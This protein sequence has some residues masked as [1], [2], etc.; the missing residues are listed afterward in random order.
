MCWVHHRITV[1]S[2]KQIKPQ[3]KYFQLDVEADYR[4]AN[5]TDRNPGRRVTKSKGGV[6]G[7][8]ADSG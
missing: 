2:S 3:K 5:A 6:Y 1:G 7:G 4:T 8:D